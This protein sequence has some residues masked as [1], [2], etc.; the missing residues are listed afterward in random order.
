MFTINYNFLII[1]VVLIVSYIL[2]TKFIRIKKSNE[3][4]KFNAAD[5]INNSVKSGINDINR[6]TNNYKNNDDDS[7]DDNDGNDGNDDNELEDPALE[8]FVNFDDN[9]KK[10]NN[11]ELGS[12]KPDIKPFEFDKVRINNFNDNFF[13]FG[14]RINN[15]SA[16][17]DPVLAINLSDH[18]QR[19]NPGDK[20]SD[21]YDSLAGVG[22][23][24]DIKKEL[25]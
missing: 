13:N 2:V 18:A 19:F 24:R 9:R 3:L 12:L 7:N 14:S 25:M 5:S 21:I 17:N 4:K 1:L 6:I 10:T 11:V 16:Y 8:H 15:S 23:Y 20:I 22:D